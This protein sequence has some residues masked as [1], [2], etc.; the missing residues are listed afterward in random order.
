LKSQ[1]NANAIEQLANLGGTRDFSDCMG[2][3]SRASFNQKAFEFESHTNRSHTHSLHQ[4]ISI[5]N[6]A[7]E[8]AT[9]SIFLSFVPGRAT[10]RMSNQFVSSSPRTASIIQKTVTPV[11]N[12]YRNISLFTSAPFPNFGAKRLV[13][14]PTSH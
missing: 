2:N 11:Q 10:R 8:H 13:S 6:C 4:Q 12:S 9:I 5:N 7:R 3:Y 14:Q 1:N